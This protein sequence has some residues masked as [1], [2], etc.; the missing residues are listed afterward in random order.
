MF[1]AF[2]KIREKRYA[3]LLASLIPNSWEEYVFSGK[4]NDY[5]L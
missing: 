3:D 1:L 4:Y 2:P 5:S